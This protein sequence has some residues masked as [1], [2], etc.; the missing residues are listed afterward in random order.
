MEQ[1]ELDNYLKVGRLKFGTKAELRKFDVHDW[2]L[3]MRTVYPRLASIYF[4]V[5]SIPTMSVEPERVFSG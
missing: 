4:D 2:W 1:D 3:G 5:C